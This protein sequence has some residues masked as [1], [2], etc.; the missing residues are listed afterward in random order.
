MKK[1]QWLRE[2]VLQ[3]YLKECIK[4]YSPWFETVYREKV[5][6]AEFN[7]QFDRY[8]DL[9][10]TLESGKRIP[11]EVEWTT[12]DFN[13][14]IHLLEDQDGCIAVLQDNL[15]NLFEGKK[16]IISE[17]KFKKWFM[18][19][20]T[21]IVNETVDSRISKDRYIKRAPKLWFYY[22]SK[23]EMKNREKTLETGVFGVPL[24]FKQLE[25]FKDIR[26]NDLV[27]LLGPFNGYK[28]GGRDSIEIFMK[29]KNMT[30]DELTLIKVIRGYDYDESPIWE[31]QT[32]SISKDKIKNYPHRFK[33]DKRVVL[34]LRDIKIN[35][36]SIQSREHLFKLPAISL[37]EGSSNTLVDL[38]SHARIG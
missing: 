12:K 25:R 27:C 30:C 11:I 18:K 4:D 9:Y 26:K 13:H 33:F 37:W 10:A 34:E 1:I 5:F 6:N 32:K 17:D 21:S 24:P 14:P 19:N 29:N 3:K 15:P 8:P 20:S 22:N 16:L 31:Y 38:I 7:S 23:S 35:N 2:K 28:K 36:L